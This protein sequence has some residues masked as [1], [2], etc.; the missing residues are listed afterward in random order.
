MVFRSYGG[1]PIYYPSEFV[2]FS[3]GNH[4]F[5]LFRC[6]PIFRKSTRKTPLKSNMGPSRNVFFLE[7]FHL[8][9]FQIG[10]TFLN[11]ETNIDEK[12]HSE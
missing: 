10:Y 11:D 2:I 1:T 5:W 4:W 9:Q 6:S 12:G 8:N 3:W 7:D